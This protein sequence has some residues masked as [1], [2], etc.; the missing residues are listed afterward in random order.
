MANQN[1][2]TGKTKIEHIVVPEV[3][4]PYVI[5]RTAELSALWQSGIV[6]R[7]PELDSLASSGGTI[8]NMPYWE[9][10]TG[11]DQVL[12]D[13]NALEV[14]K[15]EA[16]QDKA[17]L[18]MRGNAW[19]VNDLA[20]A[21]SGDDPMRVIGDLV[22]AYWARRWQAVLLST[23][24]GVFGAASM[25]SNLHDISAASKNGIDATTTL[26]A[27]QKL[28]DAKDR[29][30]AFAMHSATET[31]LAKNDLIEYIRE[32]DANPRVPTYLGKRV[33]VDDG[34]PFDKQNGVFT[35][36]IFGEGAFGLGEGAAPVPTEFDRDSL[37]GDDIMI[38]RRH[39]IL[40]PRGVAW[41]NAN[42]NPTNTE[43][44]TATNWERVYEPKNVRIVAFKHK[45]EANS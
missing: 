43:L 5:E 17:V 33:I 13:S 27:L 2:G 11:D 7:T 45:L 24:S 36:Y 44:A 28:G 21:L 35:T 39:F 29:L 19:S 20:K 40:H 38:N 42:G 8:I 10:L 25:A 6:R 12:S 15:I 41:Q 18:L 16:G 30:V 31:F 22:A 1:N 32:S 34:M 14:N 4:N 26:D 37:A 23:L 9:D 3:F